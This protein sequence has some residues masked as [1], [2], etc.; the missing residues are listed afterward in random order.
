MFA[1]VWDA[2]GI[3]P[4]VEVMQ[5]MGAYTTKIMACNCAK[6]HLLLERVGVRRIKSA[7]YI[8]PI[9]APS[10]PLRTGFTLKGEGAPTCVDTHAS[11]ASPP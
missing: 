2:A 8:S 11:K 3:I 5:V 10:T 9:P 4:Q 7:G 6:P 1:L